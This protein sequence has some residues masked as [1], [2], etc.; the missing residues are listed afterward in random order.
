MHFFHKTKIHK[1]EIVCN[2]INWGVLKVHWHIGYSDVGLPVDPSWPLRRL[3]SVFFFWL[4]LPFKVY[5]V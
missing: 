4:R 3:R 1:D 5:P 2:S